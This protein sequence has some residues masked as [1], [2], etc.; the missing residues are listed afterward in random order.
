MRYQNMLAR[1][2]RLIDEVAGFPP[3]TAFIWGGHIS[4]LAASTFQS[5]V[6]L[7]CLSP[8]QW[9]KFSYRR[10]RLA[11]SRRPDFPANYTELYFIIVLA[12]ALIMFYVQDAG[13][14]LFARSAVSVGARALG[15]L[16]ALET[17]I[18]ILYY[19]LFR[20]FIEPRYTLYHP[21]E[22]LLIFPLVLVAQAAILAD[23]SH[24][25]VT[26]ILSSFAGAGTAGPWKP[27]LENLGR[28]YLGVIIVALINALPEMKFRPSHA[29]VIVGAGSV[30]QEK[31]V[32]ALHGLGYSDADTILFDVQKPRVVPKS[33]VLR[34]M[35]SPDEIVRQVHREGL[36]AVI[37]SPTDSHVFYIRECA[38]VGIPFAVEKPICRDRAD[39]H[40]L[41]SD[42]ELMSRGFALGYYV[43]EKALPFTWL[44]TQNAA[45]KPFLAIS[46]TEDS[47]AEFIHELGALVKIDVSVLEGKGRSPADG[48]RMWTQRPPT[49]RPLI[50]TA[51]HPIQISRLA[52][53]RP[54]MPT[55][56]RIGRYAPRDRQVR[57]LK[58]GDGVGPT[59]CQVTGKSN[60]VDVTLRVGKYMPD[61]LTARRLYAEYQGG[62]VFVDFDSR[63]LRGRAGRTD[64][65]IWVR[66][67]YGNYGVQLGLFQK[68]LG[69]EQ[70]AARCDQLDSQLDAL[71]SWELICAREGGT[72]LFSYDDHVWPEELSFAA[73]PTPN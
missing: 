34:V 65:K 43:L 68:W 12:V 33:A 2:Q 48:V 21:A 36:P 42:K 19:L 63:C 31:I 64:V 67:E 20:G 9:I 17:F 26:T 72:E 51:I 52:T 45:Y 62:E 70:N 6:V 56:L 28:L 60:A 37:A 53:G 71:E 8:L 47:L 10:H 3:R 25:P 14:S 18:W 46:C 24:L 59:Y 41:R 49:L 39:L 57:D 69:D 16:L 58:L 13:I 4:L 23:L 55:N 44:V 1:C 54:L 40:T 15:S 7:R 73:T 61:A 22:S 50:E 35:S 32:P 38:K 30:T 11:R 5:F 29:I 66:P 27:L